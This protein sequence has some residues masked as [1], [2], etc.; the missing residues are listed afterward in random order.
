MDSSACRA[1]R[2]VTSFAVLASAVLV[3]SVR[4]VV[5]KLWLDFQHVDDSVVVHF[6]TGESVSAL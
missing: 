2:Q 4:F 5:S 6:S 3:S 1:C